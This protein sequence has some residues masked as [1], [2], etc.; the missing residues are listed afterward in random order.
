M[1]GNKGREYSETTP[2]QSANQES[3]PESKPTAKSKSLIAPGMVLTGD[4]DGD[5][6]VRLE[7]TL[8]G[9]LRCRAVT[10]G[11]QGTLKGTI[12]AQEVVI[13]GRIEGD[14]RAKTVKLMPTAVMIGDVHH[15]ILEVA[16]GAQVEGRYS[17]DGLKAAKTP[18]ADAVPADPPPRAPA[19]SD[20]ERPDTA[21][22]GA[23]KTNGSKPPAPENTADAKV[24]ADQDNPAK[25]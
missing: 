15:E 17:R 1:F 6:D 12:S 20:T 3:I 10:I 14:I 11:D 13:E 22:A 24:A 18:K 2:P 23:A 7:G 4:L 8:E 25:P 21:K 16:A 19:K 5:G 9:N